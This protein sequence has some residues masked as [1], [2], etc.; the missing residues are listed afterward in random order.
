[1]VI[2]SHNPNEATGFTHAGVFH[3]DDVFSTAFLKRYFSLVRGRSFQVMRVP[4]WPPKDTLYNEGTIVYDIGMGKYD[5]HGE[6][7][8]RDNGVPYAAFGKLWREF[9]YNYV[10]KLFRDM[11]AIDITWVSQKFD[12]VFIQGLDA[13]DNGT[14]PRA[15]YPAQAMSIST[16]IAN[17]NPSW[18]DDSAIGEEM[19]FCT[20]VSLAEEIMGITLER[21]AATAKARH[22][23]VEALSA[24]FNK[25]S[26]AVFERFCPWQEEI[27]NGNHSS[28]EILLYISKHFRHSFFART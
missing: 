3:A 27:L 7:D 5:H 23:V 8:F 19:C 4:N 28:A 14:M 18:E 22:I 11:P 20:A 1:M 10:S 15:D 12:S 6:T 17:M 21:M 16:L 9:G 26:I 2:L 24:T 13:V 25:G